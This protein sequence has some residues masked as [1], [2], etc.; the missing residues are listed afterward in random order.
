MAIPFSLHG[1]DWCWAASFLARYFMNIGFRAKRT[2]RAMRRN[3]HKHAVLAVR[4]CAYMFAIRMLHIQ[5]PSRMQMNNTQNATYPWNGITHKPPSIHLFLRFYHFFSR[6]ILYTRCSAYCVDVYQMRV[7]HIYI[8]ACW[9]DVSSAHFCAAPNKYPISCSSSS[10]RYPSMA[11]YIL[12]IYAYMHA[13]FAMSFYRSAPHP[14][15][16]HQPTSPTSNS[17]HCG[18]GTL[19]NPTMPHHDHQFIII[20]PI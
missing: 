10:S 16:N 13:G 8:C 12:L 18:I 2:E 17:S 11:I 7:Y 14:C 5:S 9:P 20:C 15:Q 4:E 6:F 19:N 3:K 1:N